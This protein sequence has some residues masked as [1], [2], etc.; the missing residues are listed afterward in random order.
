MEDAL[1]MAHQPATG[2]VDRV[3]RLWP[4]PCDI[5]DLAALVAAEPR[6]APPGRPWL[7]VNM[8]TSLD[9]A[10]AVDG[11]SG[12]LG[13]PADKAMFA[14]LRGVADVVLAGAGTVR[15][16]RYGPPRPSDEIRAGRRARGQ[17]EQPRIAIVTR[18]LDLD[19]TTP[20]FGDSTAVPYVITCASAD[21]DR[22]RR[23]AARAELIVAGEDTVDLAAALTQLG[24]QGAAVVAGEGGP[25]LNGDLIA[26]D[27]VDEW[28]LTI[29][30]VLAGGDAGRASAGPGAAGP[31]S[32]RLDRMIEEAGFLLTRWVRR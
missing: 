30:P 10:I 11:R 14:A 21:A 9:G 6:P 8:V 28:D 1:A 13:G 2:S 7:L 19:V 20:L 4:D 24:G 29:S 17:A 31:T 23:V 32:M 15:A 12:G 3:R 27:L 22:Q 25:S 26:A 5:D 16:E 18:S